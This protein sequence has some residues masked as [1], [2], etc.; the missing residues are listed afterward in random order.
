M[1]AKELQK[2]LYKKYKMNIP[3]HR[4]FRC[5]EKALDIIYGKWD[6]S[7]NLLPSYKVELLRCAPDSVC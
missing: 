3:Y 6:D 2:E 5:K 1:G 7:Y 4:V